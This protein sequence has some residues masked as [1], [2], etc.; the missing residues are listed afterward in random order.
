ML[1][2]LSNIFNLMQLPSALCHL[3]TGQVLLSLTSTFVD[4]EEVK[5]SRL[6][7]TPKDA[8]TPTS[9]RRPGMRRMGA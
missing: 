7:E 8:A 9:L 4:T 6:G 5:D 1:D 3:V 2:G